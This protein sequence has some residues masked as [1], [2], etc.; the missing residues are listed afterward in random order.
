MMFLIGKKFWETI[1]PAGIT[2]EVF[3]E[4]YKE[5]LQELDLNMHIKEMIER[6]VE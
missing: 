5:A 4:I 3:A 2:Y 1:L 6:A